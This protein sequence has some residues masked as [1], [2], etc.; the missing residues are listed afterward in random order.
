[1]SP[2]TGLRNLL[3]KT[4]PGHLLLFVILQ[5]LSKRCPGSVFGSKFL[6]PVEG[7]IEVGTTVVELLDLPAGG[8]VVLQPLT[9]GV[10]H[11]VSEQGGIGRVGPLT[12]LLEPNGCGK[13]LSQGVPSKVT[14]LQELLDVLGSRATS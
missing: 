12:K 10:H 13:V 3:P 14:L 11:G 8:L 4:L 9:H 7:D 5:C 6:S 1:M 2:S